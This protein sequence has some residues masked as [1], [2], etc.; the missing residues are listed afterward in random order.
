MEACR[1]LSHA[2]QLQSRKL[3]CEDH[4]EVFDVKAV[5]QWM[6]VYNVCKCVSTYTFGWQMSAKPQT[7]FTH[8][9]TA[10]VTFTCTVHGH[11][12]LDFRDSSLWRTRAHRERMLFSLQAALYT[13][14][15]E[16]AERAFQK[17]NSLCSACHAVCICGSTYHNSSLY[18]WW[19]MTRIFL[20][21]SHPSSSLH[22]L[23]HASVSGITLKLIFL[24]FLSVLW[25][26][27]L[28]IFPLSCLWILPPL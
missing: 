1:L 17:K 18:I 7:S 22:A 14:S 20:H 23:S 6:N 11:S 26:Y 27:T 2:T 3:Q 10:S 21:F 16:L 28:N 25:M 12:F 13:L 9:H 4:A 8:G 15:L 19:I 24:S 5:C